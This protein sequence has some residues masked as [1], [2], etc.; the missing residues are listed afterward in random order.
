MIT[1]HGGGITTA[2]ENSKFMN[3]LNLL[4]AAVNPSVCV[5]QYI[6]LLSKSSSK[7]VAAGGTSTDKIISGIFGYDLRSC[8]SGDCENNFF[9]LFFL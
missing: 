2:N 7:N 8:F 6:C 3:L 5:Q 4:E 1:L 9:I